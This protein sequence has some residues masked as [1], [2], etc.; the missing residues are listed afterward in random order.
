[1]RPTGGTTQGLD[2]SCAALPAGLDGLAYAATATDDAG[3]VLDVVPCFY[4]AS[5]DLI[6]CGIANGV[7]SAGAASVA[8]STLGGWNVAWTFT[9]EA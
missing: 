1:M 9:V 5:G 4:D 7:V 6:A 3:S 2:S 8:I